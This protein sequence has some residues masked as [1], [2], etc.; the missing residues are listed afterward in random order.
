MTDGVPRL[1]VLLTCALLCAALAAAAAAR[2]HEQASAPAAGAVRPDPGAPAGATADWL[3]DEP[4]VLEHWLPYRERDLLRIAGMTRAD[5]RAEIG[6]R[7]LS[8]MLRR[9]RRSPEAVLSAVLRPVRREYPRAF[10]VLAERA[11]RTFGHR[12]LLEHLLFHPLHNDS[13]HAYVPAAL[14]I[15]W[16]EIAAL[17]GE[18]RTL[19]EVARSRGVSGADLLAGGVG[20]IDASLRRGLRERAIPRRQAREW[21][22]EARCELRRSWT[23]AYERPELLPDPYRPCGPAS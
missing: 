14:G 3:P 20:T 18:G 23:G 4:W 22:A 7:A 8:E 17:E 10:A 16:A 9:R 11:R 12:H 15:G 19:V 2:G 13:L 1:A 5:I 21:G 6:R